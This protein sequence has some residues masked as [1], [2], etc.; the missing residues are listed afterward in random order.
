M[1]DFLRVKTVN[2]HQTTLVPDT[3][4]VLLDLVPEAAAP[5]P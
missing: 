5:H 3:S 2:H 1:Y 4:V